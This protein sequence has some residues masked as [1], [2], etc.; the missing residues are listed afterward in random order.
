M[1]FE[2]K[3]IKN[4]D[5]MSKDFITFD[6]KCTVRNALR[7]MLASNNREILVTDENNKL[8]G[9][10]TLNDIK[11][12]MTDQK[13]AILTLKEIMAECLITA[14]MED[15]LYQSRDIMIEHKISVLPVLVNE[16]VYGVI[17]INQILER[18]YLEMEKDLARL[19]HVVNIMHEAVC[20]LDKD[21]KVLIWNENAAKLY[22]IPTDEILGKDIRDFFP[23]AI[24]ARVLQSHTAMN[25]VY[26]QPKE[27]SHVI[28]NAEPI[29]INGEF[30]GVVTTDRDISEV[31]KLSTELDNAN[32]TVSFLQAQVR[33]I[34]DD[35]FGR[36]IGNSSV[37]IEQVNIAKQV[38]KS[39]ASILITGESGTGKEVF[40]RSI[41]DYANTKNGLFVPINCSAIP[42]E[43]FESELFGYE[44]GAFT[45]ASKK[46]KM[47]MFELA[48]NG[49]IFLDEI[50]DMPLF[51]QAKILRVLQERKLKRVGGEKFIDVN[52][53]VISATHRNLKQMVEEG[54]FRED[55]YY[56]LNVIELK[57]PA[58][59]QRKED[60]VLLINAFI[61][62]ISEKNDKIIEGI[63]KDALEILEHYPWKGNIRELKNTIEY[64]VVLCTDK[65]ITSD[66]IPQNIKK[67]SIISGQADFLET[68]I[69]LVKHLQ[70]YEKTIIEKVLRQTK[71]NKAKTAKILNIPR[72]TLYY[73]M[74]QFG[75]M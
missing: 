33:N 58:L 45:G 44:A 36:V 61:R 74:E 14:T 48:H 17:R 12:I 64:L 22:N 13:D 10:V 18:F 2:Y 37:I 7:T 42:S 1:I 16:K 69:D 52:A 73:K 66:L 47:G 65:Y 43:L 25:S 28:V 56:R 3:N 72:T 6:G 70:D 11:K 5:V 55:L 32:E 54:T 53:R 21:G 49:T 31:R 30:N 59:R 38:A 63:T 26:H 4:K 51:M 20:L 68:E 19:A 23:D 41:H 9:V 24:N 71:G 29:F 34:A 50:G 40:A 62:E 46:G 27:G 39:N 35:N 67:N 8:I 60:I 15:T 57:L 75:L